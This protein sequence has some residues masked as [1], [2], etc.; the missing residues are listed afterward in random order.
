MLGG[1]KCHARAGLY[2][3]HGSINA[4]VTRTAK[5]THRYQPEPSV[6]ARGRKGLSPSGLETNLPWRRVGF[7]VHH[8]FE[9]CPCHSRHGF[10]TIERNRLLSWSV[11]QIPAD[12]ESWLG[13][14]QFPV[15]WECWPFAKFCKVILLHAALWQQS[16]L[17][18]CPASLKFD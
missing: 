8:S 3:S 7:L 10:R 1:N 6:A 9:N 14:L 13:T 15:A 17:R 12:Q 2:Y 5:V 11:G 18:A 16:K 4:M